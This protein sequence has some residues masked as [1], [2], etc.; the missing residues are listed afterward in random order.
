MPQKHVHCKVERR[1]KWLTATSTGVV[2][3]SPQRL[4]Q[5]FSARPHPPEV[6]VKMEVREGKALASRYAFN[7]TVRTA[8]HTNKDEC[9]GHIDAQAPCSSGA[10]RTINCTGELSK[11]QCR[12]A[13]LFQR[14]E[15]RCKLGA[16]F[17][18]TL[19]LNNLRATTCAVRKKKINMLLNA[20][21]PRSLSSQLDKV[22]K[23]C[24][25]EHLR[26]SA[27]RE[28]VR[29]AGGPPVQA[30]TLSSHVGEEPVIN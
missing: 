26:R 25:H 29:P 30:T 7:A 13:P 5:T 22:H 10:P 3:F 8:C 16:G 14:D 4:R 6:P 9:A 1:R 24:C 18:Q 20:Y 15:G 23:K 17:A 28:T 2:I 11:H 19:L 27:K 12:V 21:T